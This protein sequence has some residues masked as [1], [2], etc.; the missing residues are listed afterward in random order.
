MSSNEGNNPFHGLQDRRAESEVDQE[1]WHLSKS[2][3][4]A[5]VIT[6]ILQTAVLVSW[7]ATF[8]AEF[9]AHRDV[10]LREFSDIR[11]YI[12]SKTNDRITGAEVRAEFRTRDQR[13][14]SIEKHDD[15]ML[16]QIRRVQEQIGRK[17]ERIETKLD[18]VSDGNKLNPL[19]PFNGLDL[20]GHKK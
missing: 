5:F 2:V 19:Y 16:G 4:L 1:A 7:A 10:S 8:R 18:K 12:D 17:L 14:Q 9:T 20:Q 6:L 13:M 15:A 3:P 11:T